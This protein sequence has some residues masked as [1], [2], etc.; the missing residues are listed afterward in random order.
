M[1]Q[2]DSKSD[3]QKVA[4]QPS[5]AK[6]RT[7]ADAKGVRVQTTIKAGRSRVDQPDPPNRRNGNAATR[8]A[9]L[10]AAQFRVNEH[11]ELVFLRR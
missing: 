1:S 9:R 11:G 7:G 6:T 5:S 8:P 3:S 4:S 10:V 2:T